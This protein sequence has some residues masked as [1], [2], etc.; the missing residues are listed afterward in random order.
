[1]RVMCVTGAKATASEK[2]FDRFLARLAPAPPDYLQVRDRE[3]TDRRLA[4]LL[5]RAVERLPRSR[6]LANARFDLALGTGA[7]GVVLPEAGLPVSPVRSET[8]R[9]FL[10]GK[11]AHSAAGARQAAQDGADLVLLGPIFETP[12]KARFGA[13]LSPS[14]L[15]E[16][17]PL[18]D[19]VELFLIGGIGLEQIPRLS[20]HRDRFT[21]V[22]A[23][24]AFESDEAPSV[25][26]A[27]QAM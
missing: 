21:G 14:I 22:A 10:I 17:P 9:G 18:P 23:I 5:E 16:I 19:G 12:S 25:V 24:R 3:A 4:S 27:L 26:A 6:V 11:S 2:E 20:G 1:M 15:E 8:P 13:P 7:A